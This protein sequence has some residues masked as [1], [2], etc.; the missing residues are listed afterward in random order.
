LS[1]TLLAAVGQAGV[2]GGRGCEAL[3]A[4]GSA[5]RPPAAAGRCTAPDPGVHPGV[6][7]P[8]RH[9]RCQPG[10][11]YAR[12]TPRNG[13]STC[14]GTTAEGLAG[15]A[16]R[17]RL[18]RCEPADRAQRARPGTAKGAGNG[19][20]RRACGHGGHACGAWPVAAAARGQA[21]AHHV[22]DLNSG[23]IHTGVLDAP[24]T[25]T[26]HVEGLSRLGSVGG[27]TIFNGPSFVLTTRIPYVASPEHGWRPISTTSIL[28]SGC[29]GCRRTIRGT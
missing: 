9:C 3:N 15:A 1:P 13:P 27:T 4:Y 16:S 20:T 12:P 11:C 24:P 14:S 26:S 17:G 22:A 29:S 5:G 23:E 18:P 2:D 21:V 8:P 25:S 7:L 10:H 28:R 19:H 6:P